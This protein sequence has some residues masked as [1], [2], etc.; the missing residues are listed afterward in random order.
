[1]A[2]KIIRDIM[3][4]STSEASEETEWIFWESLL[5]SCVELSEGSRTQCL[6]GSV[7]MPRLENWGK[8]VTE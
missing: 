3:P 6:V 1:M 5:E 8:R 2:K 4:I 7:R